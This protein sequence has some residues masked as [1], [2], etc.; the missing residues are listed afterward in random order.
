MASSPSLQ[1]RTAQPCEASF[2]ALRA[3]PARIRALLLQVLHRQAPPLGAGGLVPGT[4]REGGKRATTGAGEKGAEGR[5]CR[6][7]EESRS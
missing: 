2:I 7:Q 1:V 6:A 5:L 3:S 4:S